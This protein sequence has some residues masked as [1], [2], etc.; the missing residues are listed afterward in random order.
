MLPVTEGLLV[1]VL[2]T[3]LVLLVFVAWQIAHCLRRVAL[4][5]RRARRLVNDGKMDCDELIDELMSVAGSAAGRWRWSSR[6]G[7]TG[8]RPSGDARRAAG[9]RTGAK[10]P[11]TARCHRGG[12][13]SRAVRTGGPWESIH[14]RSNRRS[15]RYRNRSKAWG[16]DDEDAG[17]C[18]APAL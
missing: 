15:G 10:T 8:S 17:V 11:R 7:S 13:P 9:G 5:I 12:R 16:G 3:H 4:Y 18:G 14:R 1:A 2:G 6:G